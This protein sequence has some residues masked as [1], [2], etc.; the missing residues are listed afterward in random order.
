MVPARGAA[1][2]PASPGLGPDGSGLRHGVRGGAS[3]LGDDPLRLVR[4]PARAR[5]QASRPFPGRTW[6]SM[7]RGPAGSRSSRSSPRAGASPSAS[8]TRAARRSRMHRPWRRASSRGVR[9]S[10]SETYW[11]GRM[12]AWQHFRATSL[13]RSCSMPATWRSGCARPGRRGSSASP[14]RGR[15]WPPPAAPAPRWAPDRAAHPRIRRQPALPRHPLELRAELSPAEGPRR[16][17]RR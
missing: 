12:P 17:G 11:W 5:G 10:R 9:L 4:R 13:S 6:G 3:G 8:S 7:S 2:R 15:A 14:R 1:P 16:P